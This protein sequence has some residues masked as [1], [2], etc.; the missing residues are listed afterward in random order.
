[1]INNKGKIVL[2]TGATGNQGGAV[3]HS[4]LTSG[5][6]V[7]AITRD[8]SKPV[9]RALAEKGV[10]IV[11]GDLDDRA[12]VDQALKGVYGVFSVQAFM[13]QDTAGEIRQGKT[14]ADTCCRRLR[15][16]RHYGFRKTQ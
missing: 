10:Q 4:L 8:P 14:L 11:K 5:W 13:E 9:A 2:V 12:S 7:R 6:T 3:A 16:I 15:C 1:M